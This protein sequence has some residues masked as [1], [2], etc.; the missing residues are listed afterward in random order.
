MA[1]HDEQAVEREISVPVDPD[2]AWRLVT[3]PEHL[4]QWFAREVELE[5]EPG[6][7]VRVV[8][9]DGGERH[10]V[11]EQVDAPRRLRIVW[12]AP[13]D[14]PPSSVE[15]EVTPD[16]GGSR[17]SVTER[18]LVTVDAIATIEMWAS[19]QQGTLALAA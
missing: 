1:E 14:G 6:A 11:V 9:D 4:E 19:S 17:I 16:A 15:I 5:P 8:G 10:G 12:Y 7:P 3:E 13:P 18:E 2:R